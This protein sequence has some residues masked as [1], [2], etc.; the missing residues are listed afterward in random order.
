MVSIAFPANSA[1]NAIFRTVSGKAKP[2][3]KMMLQVFDV[4]P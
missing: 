3:P 1:G 2:D 4:Q